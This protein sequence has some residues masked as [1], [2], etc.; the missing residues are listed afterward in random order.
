ME[1]YMKVGEVARIFGV[2]TQTIRDW[3]KIGL[4]KVAYRTPGKTRYFAASEVQDL[5]KRLFDKGENE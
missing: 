1:V 2:S 4:V 5:S 3:E